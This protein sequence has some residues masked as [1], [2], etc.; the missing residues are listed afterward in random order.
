[1]TSPSA[2]RRAGEDWIRCWWAHALALARREG[3]AWSAL[4]SVQ[5]AQD[6]WRQRG[7]AASQLDDPGRAL[8]LSSYAGEMPCYM[9]QALLNL[10]DTNQPKEQAYSHCS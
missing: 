4:V 10:V 1:M 5:G 2:R 8:A 7:F 3:L 9:T 6:F